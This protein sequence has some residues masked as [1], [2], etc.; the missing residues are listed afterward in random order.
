MQGSTSVMGLNLVRS[1]PSST[2]ARVTA[3]RTWIKIIKALH[4]FSHPVPAELAC[5]EHKSAGHRHG[6]ASGRA[7]MSGVLRPGRRRTRPA[8]GSARCRWRSRVSLARE[9]VE[10]LHRVFGVPDLAVAFDVS[11]VRLG[12]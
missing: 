6:G 12:A 1:A 10:V 5:A 7:T 11:P 3:L 8:A 9:R 4:L 2:F